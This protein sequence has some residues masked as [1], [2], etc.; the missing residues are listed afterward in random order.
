MGQGGGQVGHLDLQRLLL[1]EELRTLRLADVQQAGQ[2]RHLGPH[3]LQLRLQPRRA[4]IP[5]LRS[6]P[7]AGLSTVP[8]GIPNKHTR[9]CNAMQWKCN[10]Q[11]QIG[12]GEISTPKMCKIIRTEI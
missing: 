9:A 6:W 10:G 11:T 3:P 12:E 8:R 1:G 2:L 5:G 4:V 7:G